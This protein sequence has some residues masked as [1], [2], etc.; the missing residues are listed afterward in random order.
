MSRIGKMPVAVPQGVE[1]RLDGANITVKGPKGELARVL[2]PHVAVKQ[3]NN[4]L[5]ITV[6]SP[7]EKG[8]R[9]LWGL[10]RNLIANMV[11]G[12]TKGFEKKLEVI[13]V[14]YKVAG[15]GAKI[16]LD[17]GFSHEVPIDLPKGVTASV[18][19]NLITLASA[20]KELLG[21]SA[22][23]IRSVRPPEPYKGKGIKYVDEYVRRK[24]GKAAKAGA[25]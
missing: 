6:A 15:S 16:T 24:A 2:H 7:E 25:K 3:E 13:G 11:E 12:V 14:G 20:D 10:F 21:E 5:T 23:R 17:V 19:K 18:D 22:A 9:A 4:E 1:V 8:D